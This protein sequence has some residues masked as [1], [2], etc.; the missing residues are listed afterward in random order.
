MIA[1]RW[2]P[3]ILAGID[4]YARSEMLPR[5][6]ALRQIVT[7]FLVEKGIVSPGR[8]TRA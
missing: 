6:M 1:I 5:P 2:T 3:P 4:Y 7:R 8:H